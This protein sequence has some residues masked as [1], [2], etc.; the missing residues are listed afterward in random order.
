MAGSAAIR[1]FSQPPRSERG[2]IGARRGPAA[3]VEMAD[4]VRR[5]VVDQPEGV[6]AETGHVWIENSKGCAGG[7]RCVHGGATG[8]QHVDSRLRGQRVR[9][10]H[11]ATRREGDGTACRDLQMRLRC[12]DSV[13]RG[14]D[15][16]V[17]SSAS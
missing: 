4:T 5:P 13:R 6:A 12:F 9:A 2:E 1:N 16:Q 7:D 15:V 11:H 17:V 8:P 14:L 3:A 10:G